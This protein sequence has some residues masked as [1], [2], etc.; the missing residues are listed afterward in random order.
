MG[1]SVDYDDNNKRRRTHPLLMPK[2]ESERILVVDG[3]VL[4]K[5]AIVV[6]SRAPAKYP[7]KGRLKG[8]KYPKKGRLKSVSKKSIAPQAKQTAKRKSVLE[9][10][11]YAPDESP[12]WK[13]VNARFPDLYKA[14]LAKPDAATRGAR[15]RQAVSAA[16]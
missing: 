16:G 4:E 8:A 12:K 10:D 5:A 14:L 2:F 15:L 13:R 3:E 11:K 9:V 1:V 7:K 6:P